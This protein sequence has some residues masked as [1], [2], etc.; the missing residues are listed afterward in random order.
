MRTSITGS[1]EGKAFKQ[2]V[3]SHSESSI[4]CFS[5]QSK[6]DGVQQ[7]RHQE[8]LACPQ[9]MILSYLRRNTAVLSLTCHPVL[10]TAL[11]HPLTDSS[12]SKSLIRNEKKRVSSCRLFHPFSQACLAQKRPPTI[13]VDDRRPEKLVADDSRSRHLELDPGSV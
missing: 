10:R 13:L 2:Q 12:T 3:L 11:T 8:A 4:Y 1:P 6:S 7:A 5:S 9:I